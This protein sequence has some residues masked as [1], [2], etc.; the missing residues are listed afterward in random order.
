MKIGRTLI[1]CKTDYVFFIIK[2][3][4]LNRQK[5]AC[6]N[7]TKPWKEEL[8]IISECSFASKNLSLNHKYNL[9]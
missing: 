5:S 2:N 6:Q 4:Y 9:Q 8:M 7:H 1:L 3:D